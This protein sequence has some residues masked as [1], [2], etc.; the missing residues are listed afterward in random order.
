[1]LAGI[2][3]EQYA[4]VMGPTD[5]D[6]LEPL[7]RDSHT[8]ALVDGLAGHVAAGIVLAEPE[9]ATVDTTLRRWAADTDFW[10]RRSSLLAHLQT[11][12]RRGQFIGWDRFCRL[13]D[14]M[15]EEREFFIR[16]ALGWVLREAGKRRPQLVEAFLTPRIRRVSGV[17]IRE[18]IRYLDV[19]DRDRLSAAYRSR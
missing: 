13:G 5:L 14:A 15:L 2:L 8:W 11:V 9:D 19:A 10:I 18:A 12:G 7:L 6:R 3:L 17:T 16:K 1:M 4:E